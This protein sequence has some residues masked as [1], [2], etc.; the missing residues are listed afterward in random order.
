M[1]NRATLVAALVYALFSCRGRQVERV[2]DGASDAPAASVTATTDEGRGKVLDAA[3]AREDAALASPASSPDCKLLH[4]QLKQA[5]PTFSKG[6]GGLY[7]ALDHPPCALWSNGVASAEIGNGVLRL[8]SLTKTVVASLVLA[9][10]KEGLFTLDSKVETWLSDLPE[11]KDRTV[12]MLL[13]HT[14]GLQTYDSAPGFWMN[15]KSEFTPL[16]LLAIGRKLAHRSVHEKAAPYRYANTN[17]VL[18]ALMLEAV[19]HKPFAT[20]VS[21]MMTPLGLGIHQE[22]PGEVIVPTY[23]EKGQQTGVPFRASMLFGAGDLVGTLTDVVAW[24]RI[25]GSGERLTTELKSAWLTASP[26][27][28]A[29]VGYGLGVF[30]QTQKGI[31]TVRSHAGRLAGLNARMAY[32][33]ETNTAAVA[34]STRDDLDASQAA[35]AM[36]RIVSLYAKEQRPS[37]HEY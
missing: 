23:N 36:L 8:A 31:G 37:E 33:E 2:S 7:A 28:E 14:S 34:I 30:L 19:K 13:S 20:L 18:L 32:V 21:E 1:R 16:E 29:G 15:P 24:T 4:A 26:T 17:Y 5:V 11:A 10:V 22:K 35:S 25:W 12:R 3:A 6:G 9:S 27:H